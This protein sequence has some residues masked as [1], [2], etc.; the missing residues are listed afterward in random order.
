M[1]INGTVYVGKFNNVVETTTGVR[2]AFIDI[3]N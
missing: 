2:L 1:N 3:I